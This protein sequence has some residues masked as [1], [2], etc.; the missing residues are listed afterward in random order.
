MV[1]KTVRPESM[2]GAELSQGTVGAG[3]ERQDYRDDAPLLT[4]NS[5][6]KRPREEDPPSECGDEQPKPK[7]RRE[8]QKLPIGKTLKP[9]EPY[10][11]PCDRCANMQVSC[12]R[13][14]SAKG[15]SCQSCATSRA[16]CEWG[17]NQVPTGALA[18][19]TARQVR[20]RLP[21]VSSR[22]ERR[23]AV[24]AEL[25]EGIRTNLVHLVAVQRERAVEQRK[26][27]AIF[28][29]LVHKVTGITRESTIASASNASSQQGEPQDGGDKTAE[30]EQEMEEM[31]RVGN[32]DED[33]DALGSPE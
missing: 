26:A 13:Q 12:I 5:R 30:V 32:D 25:L 16:R 17:G 9:G 3:D 33:E 6:S 27:N 20:H 1:F 18:S 8:G 4:T 22:A 10:P 29:R 15:R 28:A 31:E 14:Q 11:A 24:G 2:G 21:P 7:K 23:G 19:N